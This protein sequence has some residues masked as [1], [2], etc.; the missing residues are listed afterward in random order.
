MKP[1]LELMEMSIFLSRLKAQGTYN[2]HSICPFVQTGT[3]HPSS[4]SERAPQEPKGR[5]DT[6]SCEWGG[7]GWGVPIPFRW[8]EKK[9]CTLS[10]MWLKCHTLNWS[11]GSNRESDPA[12]KTLDLPAK[13]LDPTGFSFL[14]PPPA[15]SELLIKW[16]QI[17]FFF[18]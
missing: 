3:L 1:V 17:N 15:S 6:I 12:W 4:A 8:L 13:I 9:P 7:G 14:D 18:S 2:Y 16:I 10:T 11:E 5:V